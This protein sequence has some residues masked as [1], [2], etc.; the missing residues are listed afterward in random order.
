M[1]APDLELVPGPGPDQLDASARPE[2]AVRW[3]SVSGRVSPW[4]LVAVFVIVAG[5][6]FP[7]VY[8]GLHHPSDIFAGAALGLAALAAALVAARSLEGSSP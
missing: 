7:R 5:V 8:R 1:R 6:G 4:V 3:L 2:L